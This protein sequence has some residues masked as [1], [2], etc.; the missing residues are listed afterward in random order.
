MSSPINAGR[1]RTAAAA[2]TSLVRISNERAAL[3]LVALQPGLSAAEISREAQLAQQ[4]VG[5]ILVD[6]ESRGLLKRGE[7]RRGARGQPATPIF[8]AP[9]GAFA[10]G[11]EL[12]WRH[13]SVQLVNI[14]GQVVGEERWTYAF[15]DATTLFDAITAAIGRLVGALPE[16]SR[17]RVIGLGLAG[18]SGLALQVEALGGRPEDAARWVGVDVRQRLEAASGYRTTFYNDGNAA[19]WGE[20]AA[21]P[22]P[23]P[24]TFAFFL[25][26][27]FIPAGIVGDGRLWE[28][29]TGEAADLGL[30]VTTTHGGEQRFVHSVAGLYALQKQLE[31]AGR[32]PASPDPAT[33]DWDGM[34]PVLDD[35]LDEAGHALAKAIA[36]TAAVIGSNL[37][38]VD[39]LMPR[40]IVMR[41]IEAVR[42]HLEL[43][44][45]LPDRRPLVIA[46]EQ[47]MA[48]AAKGA[49]LLLLFR[50]Y[51]SGDREHFPAA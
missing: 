19:C 14:A 50:S 29:H 16:A 6:L 24:G 8:L 11:C 31:A 40:P 38:V 44:P 41:Y 26:S 18:P 47:G 17:E 27:T 43:M 21:M 3:S 23:R 36:N 30:M 42:R 46:G 15:P 4:T 2:D 20:L 10:L 48:A 9:E 22:K 28:G 35:W 37:A 49:A 34:G 7:V 1:F 25:V 12:G 39:G 51:F 5:K 32:P 33:W 13:C 45:A